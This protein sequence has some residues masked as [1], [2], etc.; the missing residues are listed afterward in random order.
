MRERRKE[1]KGKEGEKGEVGDRERL[2]AGAVEGGIDNV[3][4][5]K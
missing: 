4:E 1:G 2:G 3:G 5:G